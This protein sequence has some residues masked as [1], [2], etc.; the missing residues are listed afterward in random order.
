MF[1]L[2]SSAY[3]AS[4]D[5]TPMIATAADNLSTLGAITIYGFHNLP[6][7]LLICSTN[8]DLALLVR[9]VFAP[10]SDFIYVLTTAQSGEGCI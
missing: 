8:I 6:M 9:R 7:V 10:R 4:F 2:G 3:V 5:C 1:N